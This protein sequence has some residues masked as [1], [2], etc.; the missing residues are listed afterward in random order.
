LC[1][2][3]KFQRVGK[4]YEIVRLRGCG[5]GDRGCGERGEGKGNE[6]KEVRVREE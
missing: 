2:T 3:A 6:D 4:G 5:K 1:H